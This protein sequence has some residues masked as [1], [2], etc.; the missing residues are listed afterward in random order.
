MNG[1]RIG[2]V[3][4]ALALLLPVAPYA[5]AD[6]A[7]DRQ[8]CTTAS[9]QVSLGTGTA[10]M[11]GQLCRP[12]NSRPGT[13]L[14]AVHGQTYNHTYWDFPYQDYSFRKMMNR[15]GYATLLI[16]RIG[17]GAS[18]VP[19]SAQLN[20]AVEARQVHEVVQRLRTG[21][22]GGV[23][24]AHVILAGHSMGSAVANLEAATYRDV[25]ALLTTSLAHHVDP[26]GIMAIAQAAHSPNEDPVL[27]GRHDYDEGY[28]TTRP[29]TRKS[30]Y[31]ANL[32]IDPAVLAIDEYTKDANVVSESR[33]P[34]VYD[35]AISRKITAPV[36][37]VLGGRDPLFCA[38]GYED[39]ASADTVRAQEAPDWTSAA[40]F[41]VFVLP[42]TGHSPNLAPNTRAYQTAARSWADRVVGAH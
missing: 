22:I 27:A 12:A 37:F 41:E 20:L 15:A 23:P 34:A 19:P 2:A 9:T 4:G 39:C 3:L 42:E 8:V 28:A 1:R 35:P 14:L 18:T 25:D 32:P 29:G 17:M 6:D 33:D 10:S 30:V 16:D 26:A 11:W 5:F 21:R 36:L 7:A 40:G 24:F 31:Y 38:P 13:V